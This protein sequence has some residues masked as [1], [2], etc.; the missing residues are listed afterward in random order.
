MNDSIQGASPNPTRLICNPKVHKRIVNELYC[1]F[2]GACFYC[3]SQ[4]DVNDSGLY[5]DPI[6]V[7]FTGGLHMRQLACPDCA[8]SALSQKQARR[9][10]MKGASLLPFIQRLYDSLDGRCAYCERPILIIRGKSFP[11]NRATIDHIFPLSRG[12]SKSFENLTVACFSCNNLKDNMTAIEFL[13]ALC[14]MAYHMPAFAAQ[15]GFA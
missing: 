14:I 13:R 9:T 1:R 5:A 10:V 6:I 7:Q 15:R 8:P 4:L 3:S 2:G 11:A 12:G